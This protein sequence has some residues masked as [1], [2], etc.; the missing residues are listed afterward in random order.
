M[1]WQCTTPSAKK[2]NFDEIDAQGVKRP[3]ARTLQDE[4]RQ[5]Q[6][7]GEVDSSLA[8]NDTVAPPHEVDLGGDG[9]EMVEHGNFPSTKEEHGDEK[10]EP[11][12]VC[13][14]D[15]MVPIPCEHE[16]H[17]AHLSESDGVE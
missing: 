3:M 6:V 10:T 14:N 2:L 13:L 8:F 11:T 9:V 4:G 12:H 15:D 5:A 1:T 16:S 17:L 7:K